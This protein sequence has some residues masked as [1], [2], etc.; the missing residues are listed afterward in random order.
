MQRP[1]FRAGA[2]AAGLAILMLWSANSACVLP[3]WS[4][5]NH[6]DSSSPKLA[7]P[8]LQRDL[9]TVDQGD[10]LQ[11]TFRITNAGRRRLV[12]HEEA[13][14]CCGQSAESRRIIVPPGRSTLLHVEIDTAPWLGNMEHM[15]R[16]TTN[17]PQLPQL[18][19]KV[20]ALVESPSGG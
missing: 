6:A 20:T 7:L 16:Y 1:S 9:G 4:N 10:V 14:R 5:A 2:C 11:T 15:A 13:R 12:L 18:A 8:T 17:D 3:A 19:L